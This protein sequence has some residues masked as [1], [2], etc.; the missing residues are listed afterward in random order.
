MQKKAPNGVQAAS[1]AIEMVPTPH[2]AH[3]S[4]PGAEEYVPARHVLHIVTSVAP[5]AEE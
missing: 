4:E 1:P 2:I 3:K 5:K